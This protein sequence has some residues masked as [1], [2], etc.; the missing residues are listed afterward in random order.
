MRYRFHCDC[1]IH[2]KIIT[3]ERTHMP[4]NAR[5][6]HTGAF[7]PMKQR[8]RK[9]L[10]SLVAIA[11]KGLYKFKKKKKKK[12]ITQHNNNY[13]KHMK[14]HSFTWQLY[15]FPTIDCS[16]SL[17]LLRRILDT[18]RILKW[19]YTYNW[20]HGYTICSISKL[21][22]LSKSFM[23]RELFSNFDSVS[24]C[25]SLFRI[26]FKDNSKVVLIEF[27]H[28]FNSIA[29]QFEF[30]FKVHNTIL[31]QF[32]FNFN[33]TQCTLIFDA[34]SIPFWFNFKVSLI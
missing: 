8:N 12:K 24:F 4:T 6:T 9:Q 26:Q 23:N 2:I 14:T 29:I 25:S 13:R 15:Q 31:I 18:F 3:L 33:S 27:Q 32:E 22:V 19:F 5:A 21:A 7:S 28:N 11:G 34:I 1:C 20:F 17:L 16:K 30:S 10:Y